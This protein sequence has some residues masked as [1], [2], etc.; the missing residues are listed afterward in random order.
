MVTR[1]V[2]TEVATVNSSNIA[3]GNQKNLEPSYSLRKRQSEFILGCAN[4]DHV[5][6]GAEKAAVTQT[7][8]ATSL[9]AGSDTKE[10]REVAGL[11]YDNHPLSENVK[12]TRLHGEPAQGSKSKL[13]NTLGFPKKS[14]LDQRYRLQDSGNLTFKSALL[15]GLG[16]GKEDNYN[17]KLMGLGQA[18]NIIGENKL[19]QA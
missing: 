18:Q 8:K 7:Q 14:T 10:I 6:E 15:L 17:T 19:L 16:N 9:S 13:P 11:T 2:T 4:Q 12:G 3:R 5:A 1:A